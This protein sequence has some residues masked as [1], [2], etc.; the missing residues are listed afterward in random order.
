MGRIVCRMK[1]EN[2]G[3]IHWD[4]GLW[5]Q[6]RGIWRNLTLWLHDY[7]GKE[8]HRLRKQSHEV[9]SGWSEE[10]QE[11]TEVMM[12]AVM[13]PWPI[14]RSC[15]ESGL[16]S[17]AFILPQWSVIGCG[18]PWNGCDL[19]QGGSL[20]LRGLRALDYL[21]PALLAASLKK[22]WEVHLRIS[23]CGLFIPKVTCGSW[24]LL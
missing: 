10:E 18:P 7:M 24:W 20:Q 23:S 6:I 17:Q 13:Q 2:L 11:W 21:L 22:C 15:L 8:H 19:E 5:T 14:P 16:N 9:L 4:S 3:K 12:Q 1:E